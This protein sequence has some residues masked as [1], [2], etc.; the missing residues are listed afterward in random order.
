MSDNAALPVDQVICGDCLTVM[1]SWPAASVDAIV[2]DCPYGLRFMNKAWDHGVPGIPF[3]REA[4]RVA[5]P[6]AMMLAFGGTRTYHRLACAIEDAGWQIRDCIMYIYGSGFPKSKNF[7]K[8]LAN[9]AKQKAECDVRFVRGTY[10]SQAVYACKKCGQV[11]L[12]SLPEQGASELREARAES[13][14]ARLKESSLERRGDIETGERQLPRCEVCEMSHGLLADGAE[15]WLHNGASV[16]NGKVPWEV[17]EKRGGCT[18]SKPR[19]VGQSL[20]EFDAVQLEQGAQAFRGWG[21]ALKPAYEPILVAMKPLDGTFAE[22]ALK[23][24]VAGINVDESRVGIDGGTRKAGPPSYKPGHVLC[25]SL[26]GSLNGGGCEPT[27]KGH[28][29]ANLIHDGSDEVVREF[30]ET[31]PSKPGLR[32]NQNTGWA[33]TSPPTDI[34]VDYSD[35][36]SA[37]RFFKCCAYS[38]N[39]LL[40]GRAKAI[41][42][43]WNSELAN[44]ADNSSSLSG[45]HVASVLNRVV[46]V[47]SRGVRQLSDVTGLSTSVTPIGLRQLC[48]SVI[49][50]SLNIDGESS[51]V[52]FHIGTAR[53]NGNPASP[54]EILLPTDTTTITTNPIGLDGSAVVVTLSTTNGNGVA[55]EGAS[56]SRLKYCAKA[57][58]AERNRGCEGLEAGFAPTMGD[59]IGAKEHNPEMAT[60]KYNLHPTV[61]PLALMR[62]L[63]E[64]I[65]RPEHTVLDPFA[66]SG[67]TLLAAKQLGRK[68]IGIEIEQKYCDIAVERLARC[69]L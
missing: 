47:A 13:E 67:T 2:T 37:A 39:E 38:R 57:S 26:D 68:A 32:R 6:G 27:G 29:P 35:S 48:E 34:Q 12:S 42:R 53:S 23:W 49:V 61:K 65:S 44:T 56:A 3:W 60:R 16:D 51:P 18:S 28:W 1:K 66:G 10:L 25:G 50:A 59:G 41:L 64:L 24:G 69:L 7:G 55:G 21:T 33:C 63:V 14:T 62:Y 46:T 22:N 17:A 31:T 43:A 52:S 15:G 5:K 40:L 19:S 36:G 30:P 45:E 58:K 9:G 4:L 8:D 11:L 20:R 54:A